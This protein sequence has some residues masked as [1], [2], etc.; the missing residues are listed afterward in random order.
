LV[1]I[2]KIERL[3]DHPVPFLADALIPVKEMGELGLALRINSD[4]PPLHAAH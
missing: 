1:S 4:Q 3:S 2:E